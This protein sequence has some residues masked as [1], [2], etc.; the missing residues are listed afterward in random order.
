MSLSGPF[1]LAGP[2][3]A[4]QMPA[5]HMLL[6]EIWHIMDAKAMSL[7]VHLKY[8]HQGVLK[9]IDILTPTSNLCSNADSQANL[10]LTEPKKWA[11]LD[12]LDKKIWVRGSCLLFDV[13]APT[14]PL[15]PLLLAWQTVK[16]GSPFPVPAREVNSP[17]VPVNPI[18]IECLSQTEDNLVRLG[19][20]KKTD[21][22]TELSLLV[23]AL[24]T[25][26]I[27]MPSLP[28]RFKYERVIDYSEN[29]KIREW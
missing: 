15:H 19:L 26:W 10:M 16:H 3:L 5:C 29:G 8:E 11:M 14:H 12:P 18:T 20:I 7:V 1:W 23:F 2:A 22:L 24:N 9:D 25:T 28:D 4:S 6:Q 27:G 13:T 17:P 21:N